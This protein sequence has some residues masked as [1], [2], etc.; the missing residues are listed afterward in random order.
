MPEP[1][2]PESDL[3]VTAP[4][5][6][7]QPDAVPLDS[8]ERV[9][10][11][12][13]RRFADT[14]QSSTRAGTASATGLDADTVDAAFDTLAT[15]RHIVLRPDATGSLE[16]VMAHPFAAINLGFSV[17]GERTLWWG[18]CAWDSFAVPHLVESEPSVLVATTCPACETSHAWTVTREYP[19]PGTQVAHFLTPVAQ[20]W[21]DVVHTCSN[22]RIFCDEDC[23]ED[24][25]ETS[26][27]DRGYVFDLLT[28]WRLA[29]HWYE[30]RLDSPYR[31]REPVEAAAYFRQVGLRGAFWGL[32]D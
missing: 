3:P 6:G 30:G 31:R 27:N 25:L 21:D 24:W 10:H 23:V 9:R 29:Q 18:G 16:I 8:I 15:Q 17:M 11:A 12:I 32:E 26:G 20:I 5:D 7:A 13:Y 19:P 14:G 28:L 1:A 4:G 22:Q 2:M